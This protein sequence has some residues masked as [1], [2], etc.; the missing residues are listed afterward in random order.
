[1]LVPVSAPC[2]CSLRG[3]GDD[4]KLKQCKVF[5]SQTGNRCAMMGNGVSLHHPNN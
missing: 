1:M 2:R 3:V 4:E 5:E